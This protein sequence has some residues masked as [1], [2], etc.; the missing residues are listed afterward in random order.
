MAGME[1]SKKWLPQRV[2]DSDVGRR[3]GRLLVASNEM[4][5]SLK[6]SQTGQ[7]VAAARLKKRDGLGFVM[8]LVYSLVNSKV[9]A[10]F[11]G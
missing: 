8:S 5:F 1:G 9:R 2:P 4:V 11:W 6:D 10:L 7:F 3:S